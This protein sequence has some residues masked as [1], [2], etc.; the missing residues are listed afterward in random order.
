M[1]D[2]IQAAVL[3]LAG[4]ILLAA[5][6]EQTQSQEPDTPA[7]VDTTFT[8]EGRL[9][10]Q[11]GD[12]L[13]GVYDFE[14]KVFDALT[15]GNQVGHSATKDNVTVEDGLYTV[16]L[17]FGSRVFSG[18]IRYLEIGVRPGNRIDAYTLLEA[19]Q[20]L[21]VAPAEDHLI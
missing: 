19:R 21:P 1:Y 18:D 5:L 9:A 6:P 12:P 10:D 11:K 2:G 14:F 8:Y 20:R 4:G 15:G 7:A 16:E 13:E 3:G 17:D